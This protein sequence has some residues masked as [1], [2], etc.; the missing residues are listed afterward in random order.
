MRRVLPLV[1]ALTASTAADDDTAT[2]TDEAT[3]ASD[4]ASDVDPLLARAVCEP[5]TWTEP[6]ACGSGPVD[7]DA[8]LVGVD[9]VTV[10]F[11]IL[12][13]FQH[14]LQVAHYSSVGAVRLDG[15]KIVRIQCATDG[16][17]S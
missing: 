16:A 10:E 15:A 9:P 13:Q 14:S 5:T 8:L 4:P 3:D 7:R 11:D 6:P 1:L 17:V 12:P 2:P